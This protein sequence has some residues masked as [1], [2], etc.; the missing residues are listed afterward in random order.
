MA[1]ATKE[2]LPGALQA[3]A[4]LRVD[5]VKLPPSPFTGPVSLDIGAANL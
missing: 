1:H 3:W 4:G 2:T 5:V